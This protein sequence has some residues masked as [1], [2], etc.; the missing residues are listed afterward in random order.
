M[1]TF[2]IEFNGYWPVGACAVVVAES[3][4]QAIEMMIE[5]LKTMNLTE[6]NDELSITE[7]DIT[8]PRVTVIF[9]GNY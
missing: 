7:I 6:G 9:D 4:E 5:K 2:V 1:K 3:K 8:V